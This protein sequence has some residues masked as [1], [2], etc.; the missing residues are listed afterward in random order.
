MDPPALYQIES[1]STVFDLLIDTINETT[2]DDASLISIEPFILDYILNHPTVTCTRSVLQKNLRWGPFASE[3]YAARNPGALR[4]SQILQLVTV[5]F[6]FILSANTIDERGSSSGGNE[7]AA[8]FAEFAPTS[9]ATS[10]TFICAAEK[11]SVEVDLRTLVS[12]S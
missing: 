9:A 3:I 11:F 5:S 8:T 10:A 2:T 7:Q 1:L 6:Q 12:C 4:V